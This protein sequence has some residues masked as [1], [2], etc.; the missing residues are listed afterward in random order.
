[1]KL[2]A[3][4]KIWAQPSTTASFTWKQPS[5]CHLVMNKQNVMYLYNEMLCGG[6]RNKLKHSTD[7][8]NLKVNIII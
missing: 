6:K 7:P 1:M 5:A 3:H 4:I 8:M 2:H